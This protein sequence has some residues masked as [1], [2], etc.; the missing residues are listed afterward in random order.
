MRRAVLRLL[1]PSTPCA[2]GLL[3][4]AGVCLTPNAV[5]L[6]S[7]DTPL[8][9]YLGEHML[10]QRALI[11]TDP[12][13]WPMEHFYLDHE[14]LQQVALAA[15]HRT[16][17]LE[18]LVLYAAVG[19]GATFWLAAAWMRERQITPPVALGLLA[20]AFFLL[21]PFFYARPFLATWILALAWTW[22]LDRL[23]RGALEP[24]RWLVI[25]VPLMLV[26]VNL[27]GGF[28]LGFI[29]L[30][31]FTLAQL[32]RVAAAAAGDERGAEIKRLLWM[33]IG[34]NLFLVAS[35]AN[36]YGLRLHLH[37]LR[38]L[39]SSELIS[40]ITEWRTPAFHEAQALPLLLWLGCAVFAW[41]AG[42]RSLTPAE[43]LLAVAMLLAALKARR[44]LAMFVM[45][46]LPIVG[47]QLEALL[48]SLADSGGA[49]A[50]AA[51]RFRRLSRWAAGN[52]RARGGL[53]AAAAIALAIGG[54]VTVAKIRPVE[55][56]A[57]FPEPAARFIEAHPE[58]LAG[59]MFNRYQWGGYLAWRLLPAHR[60]FIHGLQDHYGAGH[61]QTY[62]GVVD[63]I[64]GW[65][66]YLA[67][68][69]VEWVIFGRNTPL[70]AAL[71]LHPDWRRVYRDRGADI[72]VREA[73]AA[74]EDG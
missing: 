49:F 50:G 9:L 23:A 3:A 57:K 4:F 59:R 58:L 63:L 40:G 22:L 18:G 15:V 43:R 46:T 66:R 67:Q 31:I 12:G 28:L 54:A 8:H 70:T 24:L 71:E 47:V 39:S 45:L 1:V 21:R 61:Y 51:R 19:V 52:E 29:L 30:G 68:A 74:D 11:A 60:V 41:L 32:W 36:V 2:A 37:F 13:M 53:L 27:H 65:D 33:A 6:L 10:R 72:Y 5:R 42:P 20:A 62:R 14:W 69:G 38:Y 17:G 55:L 73:A 16:L 25:A 56:T 48:A 35:V 34:G 7:W 64:P 26:W 44:N